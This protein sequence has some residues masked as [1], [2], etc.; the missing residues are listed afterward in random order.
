MELLCLAGAALSLAATLLEGFRDSLVFFCLWAFYLSLY[1]VS[2]PLSLSC[3]GFPWLTGWFVIS[4]GAGLPLLPV[5]SVWKRTAAPSPPHA[6]LNMSFPVGLYFF[7][8]RDNL[9]LETGFLCILIAPL[10]LIRGSR[11]VRDH[12]RVT[13][14]LIRWL[15]FRLMFASGVVKL[16]SRCPTWWGLTGAHL[17]FSL[18]GKSGLVSWFLPSWRL[19]PTA[20]T[21]HYETQCIPTPLAWF[22][23]QLPVWWQKLSV[24]GTFV[25]EI[26]VPL[27]FFSPVR[28][29][30]LGSFYLQVDENSGLSPKNIIYRAALINMPTAFFFMCLR[31]LS[32]YFGFVLQVL[33]Q[34]LIILSGNYNFFNLLTL[35]LCLS[36]LDDRHVHFWLRKRS[37]GSD[38]G[39]NENTNLAFAW[40][41]S[42]FY[43]FPPQARPLGRGSVTCWSWWSGLSW[44]QELFCASTCSWIRP[45]WPSPPGRVRSSA[46]VEIKTCIKLTLASSWWSLW[47]P[48]QR[49]PT[50]SSTSLWGP[51][52]FPLSGSASS[53]S[54][55]SWSP[56]CSG[57]TLLCVSM[58]RWRERSD[59]CCVF[60]QVRLRLGVPEEVLRDR[61]V[62]RVRC[63]HS[64]HVHRQPGGS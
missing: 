5:V 6:L 43:P 21:Y 55:G 59:A 56:P 61:P 9:L 44:S 25:I 34:V 48:V 12:D 17:G 13:F 60:S 32:L 53:L 41:T 63:C 31:Q 23:H 49:S 39:M 54:P 62:D 33:L 19:F 46:T 47:C 64:C 15:L 18:L 35:T 29:L 42:H 14:W 4:G 1:Q 3:L 27:L 58:V 8:L 24:V 28:R 52:P 22:A 40:L 26:P 2:R 11:G 10:T 50:T 16:T 7:S 20:L 51:S 30:R 38:G 37:I 57:W 45:K 36:L